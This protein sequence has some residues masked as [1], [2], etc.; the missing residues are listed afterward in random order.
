[1]TDLAKNRRLLRTIAWVIWIVVG[2]VIVWEYLRSPTGLVEW[3]L[4]AAILILGSLAA[5]LRT[6]ARTEQS[7]D[8]LP[9]S[10][11]QLELNEPHD[12]KR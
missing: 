7:I 11:M 2:L 8:V 4:D 1:M 12:N 9:F 6:W 3:F 10:G 5:G